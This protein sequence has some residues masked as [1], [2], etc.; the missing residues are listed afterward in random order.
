VFP[1]KQVTVRFG[2]PQVSALVH[3]PRRGDA[4]DAILQGELVLETFAVEILWPRQCILFYE[5]A[6]S[7]FLLVERYGDDLKSA[8]VILFVGGLDSRHLDNAGTACRGP[9][10]HQYDLSFEL[11]QIDFVSI[12][13]R[14]VNV[15]RFSNFVRPGAFENVLR[16]NFHGR[17]CSRRIENLP[18]QFLFSFTFGV[19][20]FR[21][22]ARVK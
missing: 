18:D 7:G 14:E 20:C 21:Q 3:E 16:Q 5:S 9:K 10:I 19:L 2:R 12:Q 13:R 1:I 6:Q 8:C 17:R 4:E 11:R 22:K 15:E